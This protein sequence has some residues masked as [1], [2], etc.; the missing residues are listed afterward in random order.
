MT[1]NDW[2]K[3][4]LKNDEVEHDLLYQFWINFLKTLDFTSLFNYEK[5]QST[6]SRLLKPRKEKGAHGMSTL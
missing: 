6:L 2:K 5:K 1:K 4:H 3:C